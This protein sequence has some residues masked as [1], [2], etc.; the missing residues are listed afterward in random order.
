MK[1]S[2]VAARSLKGSRYALR[3]DQGESEA[4]VAVSRTGNDGHSGYIHSYET[5]G[6]LDGPGIRFVTFLTG[7]HFRCQ[8]CHNPDT[9]HLKN[10]RHVT[11]DEVM[12]EIEPY[13]EFLRDFH[14][15]VT[16]SG[17]EALV[18]DRF[19]GRLLR[20]CK[21]R[22]LHTAVD[23]NGYLGDKVTPAMMADVDLWLLD[24]KSFDP[25]IHREVTGAEVGPVLDFARRL[26]DER[27]QMWVRFVLVPG[28]T[29]EVGNVD[30]LAEFVASLRKVE[31]VEIL[32]FH[33]MGEFKWAELG[34]EY[35]LTHTRPPDKKL[36]A[37]VHRQFADRGLNVV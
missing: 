35:K 33:K 24:I 17:G 18:Q 1:G 34:L 16:F 12:A 25:D 3:V 15:G 7:C 9:W 23:T 8:Y 2:F 28:L 22:G 37:R 5:G 21:E 14:S 4:A 26:S 11:V 30:R 6:T 32:P 27:R 19:L 20:R 36:L 29:D 10:G 31:R 13:A